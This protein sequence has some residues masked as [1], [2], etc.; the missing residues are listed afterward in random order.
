MTAAQEVHQH[1]VHV[2]ALVLG[3]A[4]TAT[5][6]DRIRTALTEE[7]KRQYLDE[8]CGFHCGSRGHISRACPEKRRDGDSP[9]KAQA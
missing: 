9:A 6:I 5:T 4:N 1:R 8:G 7:Q 3:G 2:L